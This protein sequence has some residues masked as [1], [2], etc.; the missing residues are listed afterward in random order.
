MYLTGLIH[1]RKLLDVT[2]R[3][4]ADDCRP[5]DG[6]FATEVF[7]FEKLISTP[8]GREFL[9]DINRAVRPGPVTSR[10]IAIKDDLRKAIV[11]AS[12]PSS[13]HAWEL[14]DRF[15]ALPEE[16]FPG[17]PA[18]FILTFGDDGALLGMVRFKRIRR[19]AEKASRR[20]A[21][22]LAGAIRKAAASL[23]G[24]RRSGGLAENCDGLVT[25]ELSPAMIDL[26][27]REVGR[28]FR[29]Y[30]LSFEPGHMRIDDLMGFKFVGTESELERIEA[31][32]REHPRVRGVEREVHRGRYND[33]NLLV[34][35]ELPPAVEIID[36][37][38]GWD[39]S[40]AGYRGLDEGTLRRDFPGYVESGERT[41][42]AEVILTTFEE[43]VE[44]E[45]GSA[46]HE[47]RVVEQRSS[48]AYAGRLAQNASF[49]VEYLLNL[50]ISPTVEVERLPVKLWGRYLPDLYSQ[51]VWSLYG[52]GQT[53]ALF[54]A[55]LLDPEWIPPDVHREPIYD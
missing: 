31:A 2:M 28:R 38:R 21:D 18:D 50:A 49:I 48:S 26:A 16:F 22:N 36:R 24:P 13:R 52:F 8:T 3:W 47:Q 32:I 40:E 25:P 51:A 44:S 27:E 6:R 53:S 5:G 20:I 45:F 43:L 42:R 17:T 19:I 4:L 23:K 41:F 9:Q 12:N 33:I 11:S 10:R 7:I 34:D 39:W 55:I 37:M 1:R 29:E 15:A 30:G 54:D 14:F 46:I 35:L